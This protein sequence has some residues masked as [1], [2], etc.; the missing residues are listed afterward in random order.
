MWA[1]TT[2]ISAT[3]EPVDAV[4]QEARGGAL[5]GALG[6]DHLEHVVLP[7]AHRALGPAAQVA[8]GAAEVLARRRRAGPGRRRAAARTASARSAAASACSRISSLEAGLDRDGDPL[9]LLRLALDRVDEPVAQPADPGL[10]RL[11]QLAGAD[12]LLPAGEHLAAQQ[13]A[14]GG[15]GDDGGDR[16]RRRPWSASSRSRSTATTCSAAASAT[17]WVRRVSVRIAPSRVCR[18]TA[19]RASASSASDVEPAADVGD[20][21]GAA[22]ARRRRP[23]PRGR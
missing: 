18:T 11:E 23:G 3:D 5:V 12:E 2:T 4:G 7:V 6:A 8:R 20:V 17:A 22:A 21:L 10:Q 16:R 9:G 15:G 1:K 19:P 13:G 14:V